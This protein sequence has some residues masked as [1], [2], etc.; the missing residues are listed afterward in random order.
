MDTS[1]AMKQSKTEL[2]RWCMVRG[3]WL[4][5]AGEFL[6]PRQEAFAVWNCVEVTKETGA[7]VVDRKDNLYKRRER[8]LVQRKQGWM[9]SRPTKKVSDVY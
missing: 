8:Y 2:C 1:K 5:G 4:A 7:F 9:D 3:R 6:R